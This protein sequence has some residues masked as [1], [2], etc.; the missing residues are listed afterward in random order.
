MLLPDRLAVGHTVVIEQ[1]RVAELVRGEGRPAEGDRVVDASGCVL[2]P[3][4]V[5][6]HVHGALGHDVLEGP[7]AV[8][9]V[10]E[11]LPRFGVTA[12]CPTSLAC[13]ETALDTLLT[14]VRMLQSTPTLG[15]RVLGA[16][17]ESTVLNADYRGAQP[18]EWLWTGAPGVDPLQPILRHQEAVALVTLAPEIPGGMDLIARLI[19][20]RL[21]VS[22][23]H[24]AATFDQAEAAFAAGA[25]RVTHLFN[26]MSPL[27][28]RDPGLVGAALARPDVLVELIG[29]GIHVHPAIMRV[30]WAAKGAHAVAA[31]TDGTSG[32]GLPHGSRARLGDRAVRV[33]AVARLEDGTIAG[34][35][36]TM[37]DVFARL[38]RDVGVPMVDAALMC[39]TT[40]ATSVG[41]LDL[42]RLVPGSHA[43]IVILDRQW[44]VRETWIG[45]TRIFTS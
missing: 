3:G 38:V 2:A 25:R 35:I 40:P 39:A 32:S 17:V 33:E 4:F 24:S 30:V 22:L 8:R 14:E 6:V 44:R 36:A 21:T 12:F 26:R 1:G 42:G 13:P 7:G 18:A 31:I 41:R 10:A 15:A 34:S 27:R 9:T 23:G 37:S 29:D 11:V 28:H 20:A 19:D 5:D 43:D 16:H 45:G